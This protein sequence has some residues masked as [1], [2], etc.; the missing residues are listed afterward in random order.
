M[1]WPKGD[2]NRY[3]RWFPYGAQ[4]TTCEISILRD[5][6]Q[7][8]ERSLRKI[9]TLNQVK[10]EGCSARSADS[11]P[12]FLHARLQTPFGGQTV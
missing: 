1:P 4:L 10:K 6:P 2:W 8:Y 12:E 9:Y 5:S 3:R 7:E 11:A